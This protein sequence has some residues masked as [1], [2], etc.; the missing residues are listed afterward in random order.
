MISFSLPFLTFIIYEYTLSPQVQN[1]KKKGSND[2]VWTL[3]IFLILFC[4]ILF[5]YLS[6]NISFF[7]SNFYYDKYSPVLTTGT[8]SDKDAI[9]DRIKREGEEGEGEGRRKKIKMQCLKR[10][11]V[12]PA[13]GCGVFPSPTRTP[14]K[15]RLELKKILYSDESRSIRSS[16]NS[17]SLLSL[18]FLF[19]HRRVSH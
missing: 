2:I 1:S 12:F 16:N 3:S 19:V 13:R 9:E 5:Y 15:V 14:F 11:D 17:L 4:F 18:L 8:L 6:T 10:L 7:I